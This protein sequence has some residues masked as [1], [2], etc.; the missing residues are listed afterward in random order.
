MGIR[1]GI[2]VDVLMG[3]GMDDFVVDAVGKDVAMGPGMYFMP[4]IAVSVR[5]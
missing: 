5:L 4:P 2:D 3:A 1:D